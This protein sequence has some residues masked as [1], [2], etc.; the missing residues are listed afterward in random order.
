MSELVAQAAQAL[1]ES[2]GRMTAQRR[3]VLETLEEIGGHPTAEEIYAAARRRDV[4]INAS[5]VYRTL[6]WLEQAGLLNPAWLGPDRCRRQ[7]PFGGALPVEHHH[8]VCTL[9]GQ[10][11]E[12]AAPA[13]EDIKAAF[14]REH[15]AQIERA[16]LTLYGVCAGCKQRIAPAATPPDTESEE[17]HGNRERN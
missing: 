4:S 9:C 1:R 15:S 11:I 14:A 16:A 8:F 13:I 17:D 3:A 10:V 5:T 12:F 2:G 6:S 7:E